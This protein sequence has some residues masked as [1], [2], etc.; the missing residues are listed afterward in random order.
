MGL[1]SRVS[2]YSNKLVTFQLESF[3]QLLAATK[4]I[5]LD[6]DYIRQMREM[7]QCNLI[8]SQI[9]LPRKQPL[10]PLENEIC[11]GRNCTHA[12]S[13]TPSPCVP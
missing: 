3:P 2:C 6:D 7:R 8:S 13:V 11:E 4:S 1:M 5:L 10:A 12:S 9:L